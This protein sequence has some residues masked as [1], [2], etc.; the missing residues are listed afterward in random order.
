MSGWTPDYIKAFAAVLKASYKTF[1]PSTL[2]RHTPA[3]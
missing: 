3:F 1:D 2:N